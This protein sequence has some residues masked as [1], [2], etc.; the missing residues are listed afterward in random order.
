M[1]R[2]QKL[3]TISVLLVAALTV[4]VSQS[5][6]A[7]TTGKITGRVIDAATKAPLPGVNVA[8]GGTRRGATTDVDGYFLILSVSP[9]IY[10]LTVSMVG[11]GGVTKT[12]VKVAADFTA[13]VDFDLKETTIK[14][15]EVVAV[16]ERPPVEPDKT[17]SQYVVS[18]EAVEALP[19]ARSIIDIVTLQPGVNLNDA[20]MIRGGDPRDAAF[21]VDGVRIENMISGQTISSTARDQGRQF[22]GINKTAVQEI[23]VISGGAGAEYGNLESGAVS[24]VTRDGSQGFHG[25]GDFRYTPPGKGHWGTNVYDSPFQKGKVKWNDRTWTSE[26]VTLGP[27]PDGKVGT[28]DDQIGLAHRRIPYNDEKGFFTEGGLSG[29]ITRRSSFLFTGRWSRLA[30]LLPGPSLATPFNFYGNLKLSFEI[31]PNLRLKIGQVYGYQETFVTGPN[32]QRDLA[33][34][35]QNVFLPDGSGVGKSKITDNVTYA[36]LTHTLSPTTFYEMK[37]SRYS[38]VQDTMD[39]RYPLDKFGFPL[40]SFAQKDLDGWFNVKPATVVDY[41]LLEQSRVN[42]KADLSSQVTKGHLAKAGVDV[43]RYSLWQL[44]YFS[45]NP[46]RRNVYWVNRV[47]NLPQVKAPVN[48]IQTAFYVQDK[49]EF[50]GMVIN[51]GLRFDAFNPNSRFYNLSMVAAPQFRWLINQVNMPTV[52]AKWMTQFSPR[53]GVSHPITSR[54]AFHFTGGLYANLSDLADYYLQGWQAN[55]PDERVAYDAFRGILAQQRAATPYLA[56]QKT[57]AYE[58]GAD[59]NFV[60]DYIFGVS[61]YYKSAIAKVSNGSRYFRD[62][63]A[64]TSVYV[65]ARN[66][67]MWQDMKGFEVNFRKGFSHY[68]SF[69][70]ALNFG[71]ATFG[72]GG[73]FTTY[74]VPTSDFINNDDLF[75]DLQW[76]AAQGKYVKKLFS[77]TDKKS[78]GAKSDDLWA[79]WVK[80]TNELHVTY[81]YALLDAQKVYNA[82]PGLNAFHEPTW[83]GGRL[84]NPKDAQD[85]RTMASLSIYYQS[86][87]GFG[88][89]LRGW[90]PLGD[91]R[92]N[93]VYRVQSGRP[94]YYTPPG[95]Q[96]E[97]RHK[98]LQSTVDLQMEKTLAGRGSRNAVFYV[99]FFNLFNQQD[100]NIPFNYTDYVQWG[101]NLPRPNDPDFLTYGDYNE[102]TRYVGNSRQ[103]NIGLR[104]NF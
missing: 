96:Q 97:L 57:R 56:Y 3:W 71:W 54:S 92:A 64:T 22:A 38:T 25:W 21:Y 52:K 95:K 61:A 42:V 62:P 93:L 37:L 55:G 28:G 14:M 44:H 76:D 88:P 8:I 33:S 1:K 26:T 99:E 91:L 40:A 23:T 72:T 30:N 36:S 34:N 82:L 20:T 39:V 45:P 47:G 98:P 32:A 77:A 103:V 35:G 74:F 51:A 102:L 79:F 9:G 87:T 19:M 29:S 49:M 65:W 80:D 94:I 4:F 18:K 60:S 89:A 7:G 6:V 63:S 46:G 53:L 59:W 50:E 24:V 48:P 12:D 17:T 70:A 15:P 58:A 66:P 2:H 86:P 101:L 84:Q 13:T 90:S 68:F 75:Y 31:T 78:L 16:A 11:Y 104:F 69:N 43:T 27:G 10:S 100:S 81:E 73:S 41:N 5:A 83:G 85:L 67:N